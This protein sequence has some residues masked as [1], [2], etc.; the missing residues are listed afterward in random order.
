M[1]MFCTRYPSRRAWPVGSECW[2]LR[3]HAVWPVRCQNCRPISWFWQSWLSLGQTA[4]RQFGHQSPAQ[5]CPLLPQYLASSALPASGSVALLGPRNPGD[6]GCALSRRT[7]HHVCRSWPCGR[8]TNVQDM[9]VSFPRH[10]PRAAESITASPSGRPRSY[11]QCSNSHFVAVN[12]VSA[13]EKWSPIRHPLV[14]PGDLMRV[15]H[16]QAVDGL[17]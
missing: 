4:R 3:S 7:R 2:L 12:V 11:W 5:V 8:R 6:E 1:R 17:V 10:A 15:F 14:L 9:V 13:W 16:L